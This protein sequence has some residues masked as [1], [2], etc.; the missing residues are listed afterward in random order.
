M[1]FTLAAIGLSTLGGCATFVAS[2]GPRTSAITD[3]PQ[4]ASLRGI[5]LVDGN[6]AVANALKK[7]SEARRFSSF[8]TEPR[9]TDYH[10]GAGDV[11]QI[12]IWEAPPAMLFTPQSLSGSGLTTGGT[13]TVVLPEQLVGNTG[14]IAVP[15]AGKIDVT[16]LTLSQIE[17]SIIARLRGKANHPQV[18]V[19]LV[20][21]NT[22]NVTVVGNVQHSMEVPVTPGGVKLLRALA[23]SGGVTKPVE[24]TTIQISR[25]GRVMTL[26]LEAILRSPQDNIGLRPGD[27]VTALYQPLSFTALGAIGKNGEVD[28]EANGINLAQ[29]LARIGGLNDNRSNPAGVFLFR[30]VPPNALPWPQKPTTLVDGKVPT[31]FQFNLR[32]PA[33]FFVAQSFPVENKDLIYVSDAPAADLQKVLNVVGSIVYPFQ[34]LNAFG[35]IH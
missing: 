25:A 33:T 14:D 12:Y 7:E 24:K 34:T 10:V 15:F 30:L 17:A 28:F 8:F 18:I 26:P 22:Q 31:I 16:G 6:Y 23:M 32:D 5:E 35:V 4:S 3:A 2:A 11:L 9:L 29:A 21:N 13:G 1:G 27:V 20:R 19:R